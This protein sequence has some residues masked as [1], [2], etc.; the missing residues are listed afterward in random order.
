MDWARMRPGISCGPSCIS[1]PVASPKVH[2]KVYACVCV[3]TSH[4]CVCAQLL[5]W[6]VDRGI[7]TI[8]TE[9]FE[10]GAVCV[11]GGAM[12]WAV[13]MSWL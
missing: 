6:R 5:R 12:R 1:A 13:I 3:L 7:N 11:A 8:L 4:A 10:V 9:P 2:L